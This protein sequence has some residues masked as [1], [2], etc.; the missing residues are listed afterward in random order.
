MPPARI[1]PEEL[2]RKLEV[3]RGPS[4]R[5]HPASW[6]EKQIILGAQE[7]RER[8]IAGEREQESRA[9]Y[10]KLGHPEFTGY[11]VFT[12]PYGYRV[13]DIFKTD[14]GL[15]VTF[16][17]IPSA[18]M[19]SSPDDRLTRR[20]GLSTEERVAFKKASEAQVQSILSGQRENP[21]GKV[22]LAEQFLRF[23]QESRKDPLVR[24]GPAGGRGADFMGG[25]VASGE[26]LAYPAL[27][28]VGAITP[29]SPPTLLSLAPQAALEKGLPYAAGSLLGDLA[30]S[31]AGGKAVKGI[32]RVTLQPKV[33]EW[34]TRRYIEKGP[35]AWQGFTE[36]AVMRLTG[37]KP[38]LSP[39]VVSVPTPESVGM[40]GLAAEFAAWDIA[41]TPKSSALLVSKMPSE[42]LASMWAK[43]HLFKTVTGGLSYALVKEEL[44]GAPVAR[45]PHIPQAPRTTPSGVSELLGIPAL[46]LKS[47]QKA[48]D[49]ESYEIQRLRLGFIERLSPKE[50]ERQSAFLKPASIAWSGSVARHELGESS[51]L[52]QDNEQVQKAIQQQTQIQ[53]QRQV[54]VT[55]PRALLRQVQV[56]RFYR[57]DAG[58]PKS[59]GK[60][61]KS[62]SLGLFG[63]YPRM[64]PVTTPEQ[65]WG[66]RK[67]RK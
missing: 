14:K 66:G 24:L 64:Y 61:K 16:E 48:K 5:E 40:K 50:R 39:G 1:E 63:R 27:G 47:P 25:I 49:V 9:F 62:K 42:R 51:L 35:L 11:Q 20:E 6:E 22:S 21:L 65:I 60:G 56:P 46:L 19:K 17:P 33:Q 18:P 31:Y 55:M 38:Y 58:W 67:R 26:S 52:R 54:S 32:Y 2:S 41:E 3:M 12:T 13:Q 4:R 53:V 37:D 34:L 29:A 43:E 45:Q 15:Q 23:G 10:T 44:A 30:I 36:K 59:K 7:R 57:E 28:L 8:F